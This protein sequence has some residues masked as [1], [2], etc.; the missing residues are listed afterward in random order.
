M[1]PSRVRLIIDKGAASRASST[2]TARSPPVT[3]ERALELLTPC[4]DRDHRRRCLCGSLFVDHTLLGL[5]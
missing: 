1:R 5:G 2:P 3:R 4:A